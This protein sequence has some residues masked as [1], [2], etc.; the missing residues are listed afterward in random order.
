MQQIFESTDGLPD[1]PTPRTDPI[2]VVDSPEGH[3]SSPPVLI[4]LDRGVVEVS[5]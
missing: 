4:H 1:L 5:I 2:E 3:Q